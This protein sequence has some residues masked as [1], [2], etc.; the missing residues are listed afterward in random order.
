M[1]ITLSN[2]FLRLQPLF[3]TLLM[4]AF[5][6]LGYC[7]LRYTIGTLIDSQP[8]STIPVPEHGKITAAEDCAVITQ[9]KVLAYTDRP[10]HGPFP[11]MAAI[12]LEPF[13]PTGSNL[14]YI[15]DNQVA[16]TCHR[17]VSIPIYLLN[18]AL[19]I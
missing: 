16:I 14:L 2:K 9:V 18:R 12:L 8:T 7:P 5:V 4:A 11:L 10:A 17:L 1:S 13:S 15:T 19:R 3:S 6:L